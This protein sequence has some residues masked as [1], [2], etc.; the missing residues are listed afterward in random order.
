MP[1]PERRSMKN[2]GTVVVESPLSA[3]EAEGF[4]ENFR[5][6]LW[7]CRAIWVE[8]RGHAIGSHMLNP[9]YMDD[10]DPVEREAGINNPWVWQR[11]TLHAFFTDRGWSRGMESA[12]GRCADKHFAMLTVRLEHYS[13]DCWAAYQRGE[14][15]P[16]TPGFELIGAA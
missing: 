11:G 10:T 16:H 3:A 12:H 8:D 4:R 1:M 14:W 7:C 9:W 6:L 2:E 15:P 13:P 5:F